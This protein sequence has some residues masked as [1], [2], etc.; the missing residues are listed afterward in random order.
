VFLGDCS[1]SIYLIH[2]IVIGILPTFYRTLGMHV[3]VEGWFYFFQLLF[4]VI[5]LSALCYLFIEKPMNKRSA[6]LFARNAEK[7]K[8]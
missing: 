4:V 5:F 1:F 7:F 6:L 3:K 8:Q 2:P